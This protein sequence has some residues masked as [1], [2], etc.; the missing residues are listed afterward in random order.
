MAKV[1]CRI[2]NESKIL[3]ST[4]NIVFRKVDYIH[5]LL[6]LNGILNFSK[7][8]TLLFSYMLRLN[9]DLV[10][11]HNGICIS[12]DFAKAYDGLKREMSELY[13]AVNTIIVA[14]KLFSQKTVLPFELSVKGTRPDFIGEDI[15]GDKSLF[16]SKGSI[17]QVKM[18]DIN[19]SIEQISSILEMKEPHS[20]VNGY[21]V[22]SDFNCNKSKPLSIRIYDPKS[23]DYNKCYI[24]FKQ[25]ISAYHKLICEI[26]NKKS[27]E[28][29]FFSFKGKEYI[30][31]VI[32]LDEMQNLIFGIEKNVYCEHID[33]DDC[34]SKGMFQK[35]RKPVVYDDI[36]EEE[37][38]DDG[39]YLK[40]F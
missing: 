1:K 20:F 25:E 23:D 19:K 12:R 16:E 4:C 39:L 13:G 28:I 32:S 36:P 30:G 18:T 6:L 15:N 14:L 17:N 21:S 38:F 2:Y 31:I 10:F 5:A 22:I 40:I 34:F 37:A 9:C 27:K 3:T 8:I 11:S 26:I 29:T 24:D 35:T 33:V 7:K